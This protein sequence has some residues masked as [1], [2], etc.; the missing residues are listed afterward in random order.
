MMS[1]YLATN[2]PWESVVS[3]KELTKEQQY[4]E[5]Y[6][7]KQKINWEEMIKENQKAR[8]KTKIP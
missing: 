2:L 5:I 3:R 6:K 1:L 8:N 4:E 7:I